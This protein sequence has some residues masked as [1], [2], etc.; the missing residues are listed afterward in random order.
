MSHA[1][2]MPSPS[3]MLYGMTFEG[4]FCLFVTAIAMHLVL[5]LVQGGICSVITRAS[6]AWPKRSSSLTQFIIEA[7]R[8]MFLCNLWQTCSSTNVR[9]PWPQLRD[10]CRDHM[11]AQCA[12]SSSP[13]SRQL[14]K[15]LPA[16]DVWQSCQL[17]ES[18]TTRSKRHDLI[19]QIRSII[20][21]TASMSP[22][23]KCP[24]GATNI[25]HQLRQ[26]PGRRS[27]HILAHA[28]QPD[29]V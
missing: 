8:T 29:N 12:E 11:S 24:G 25:S 26:R 1:S 22:R 14:S 23:R 5:W 20:R 10:H 28:H 18:M 21:M 4:L 13:P 6:L 17:H 19:M 3:N 15:R 7:R 27:R 16:A 2:I 9:C